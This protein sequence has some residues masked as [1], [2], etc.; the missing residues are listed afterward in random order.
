MRRTKTT[1]TTKP[2]PRP[3][4]Y[5]RVPRPTHERLRE[6]AEREGV[7]VAEAARIALREYFRGGRVA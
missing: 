7:T 1:P 4:I 3:A 5:F 2:A 6:I